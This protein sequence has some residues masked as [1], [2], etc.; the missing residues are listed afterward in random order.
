MNA[1]AVAVIV[2]AS[3]AL[4]GCVAT[5]K[6]GTTHAL[7]SPENLPKWQL[8]QGYESR[9]AWEWREG[10]YAGDS[11]C[12]AYPQCFTNFVLEC[13]VLFQGKSE[14]GIQLRSDA[15]A[16]RGWEVG[17]ELDID[18]ARDRQH[19][20]IHFPVKPQPYC[21]EALFSV[22][23]WH[24]VAVTANGP[25]VVV[26]LDGQRVLQFEDAEYASGQICLQGEKDGVLYR[27]LT[28]TE[29]R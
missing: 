27:N 29:L 6:S 21:G 2:G 4:C 14:G 12:I 15:A 24:S 26:A 22:G 10:G 11:S 5:P 17:Y 13:E 19:G 8:T 1:T 20:H 9:P 7:L 25:K 28:V 3:L 18:W 16:A 23:E